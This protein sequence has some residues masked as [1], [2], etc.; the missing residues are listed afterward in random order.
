LKVSHGARVPQVIV[1]SPSSQ[2]ASLVTS[3][4]A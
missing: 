2:R 4:T 3:E 1:S